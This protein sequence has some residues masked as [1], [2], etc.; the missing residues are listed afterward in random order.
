MQ[1]IASQTRLQA[2]EE[3]RPILG[4][5]GTIAE[6]AAARAAEQG[7][8]AGLERDGFDRLGELERAQLFA[9]Q[10]RQALGIARR[11]GK[12]HLHGAPRAIV[13]REAK[14]ESAHAGMTGGEQP[15]ELH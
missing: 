14:R 12:L 9:Q 2:L 7:E 8:V 13:V 11:R 5:T 10:L 15:F 1:R 6:Q 3:L 4:F